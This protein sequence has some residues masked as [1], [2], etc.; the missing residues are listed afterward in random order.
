MTSF[1]LVLILSLTAC[2]GN[3]SETA[4]DVKSESSE[5]QEQTDALT[6][7][8]G[9]AKLIYAKDSYAV[10]AFHGPDDDIAASFC[11]SKFSTEPFLL[12]TTII[13]PLFLSLSL[14]YFD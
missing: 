7:A 13:I 3:N 2:G 8:D 10:A 9:E 11:L 6:L 1:V 12:I 5:T 4:S 14:L